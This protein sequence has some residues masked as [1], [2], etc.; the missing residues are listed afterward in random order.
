MPRIKA[1]GSSL[2]TPSRE[3][4]EL[5]SIL[6]DLT[7]GHDFDDQSVHQYYLTL[8][9]IIG[10]WLSERGRLKTEPIK[11]TLHTMANNLRD[12]SAFLGGFETHSH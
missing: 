8:A 2:M 11:K 7:E 5:K 3:A 10:D 9:S 4:S 12:A 6:C 1:S